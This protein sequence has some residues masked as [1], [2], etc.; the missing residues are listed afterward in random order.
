MYQRK[1]G[2]SDR[3]N[4][5]FYLSRFPL[6]SEMSIFS[7][8]TANVLP[9]LLVRPDRP[10]KPMVI[11]NTGS[12]R[13]DIFKGPFTRNDQWIM[14]PFANNFLYVKDVP[15][16][17]ARRVLP[18]LNIVGEHGFAAAG[19]PSEASLSTDEA[20]ARDDADVEQH[21]Q[22]SLKH[23][24]ASHALTARSDRLTLGYVTKDACPGLGD[25]TLHKPFPYVPQPI[26]V[27]T[28]LDDRDRKVDIVFLDFIKIDI[29][30]ALNKLQHDRTYSDSD[31]DLYVKDLSANTLMQ[32]YAERYW[33]A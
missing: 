5:A 15:T 29:V 23:A 33:N 4:T 17:L 31:V 20:K 10:A 6:R 21:Y 13:F 24:A 16:S 3:G 14:Q 18:Y 26:F 12:V 27:S 7:L 1:D 30:M 8:L 2:L 11:L 19:A 25:D 22:R 32:T 9:N 28:E